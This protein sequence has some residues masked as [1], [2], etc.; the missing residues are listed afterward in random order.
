MSKIFGPN[1]INIISRNFTVDQVMN[2]VKY[3][4]VERTL[5]QPRQKKW[6]KSLLI[7]SMLLNIPLPVFW[8]K[9]RHNGNWVIVDGVQRI[10]TMQE[11]IIDNEL[12]L[13]NLVYL[14][15]QYNGKKF[16]ELPRHMQRRI[17]ETE[18]S[19]HLIQPEVDNAVVHDILSRLKTKGK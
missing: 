4:E 7:E 19:M 17:N 11:F 6:K 10:I 14:M 2:R 16:N 13:T 1:A 5:E 18:L 9:V 8:V 15:D 3:G 12:I